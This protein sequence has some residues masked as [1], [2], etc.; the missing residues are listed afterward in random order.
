MPAGEVYDFVVVGAGSAG[1]AVAHRLATRTDATVLLIEAG[2]PDT[3]P[4]IHDERM[5]A[6][7]SLWG[8]SEIDWGYVTEPQDG[9]HG[10]T[11][12]VAR[13]KV[14][15]GS[16]SINAMLYVRGNRRDFD[17]WQELGNTG[18]GY[19]DVLPHFREMENF[20]G[21]ASVY[22]GADGPLSV[23]YH[24]DPTPVADR[25]F[26]AGAEIG[27]RA[28]D[29]RFDYNAEHQEDT[30][31]YY[32]AT[33][34]RE[35]RRASTAVAYLRPI[36]D[37]PNFTLRSNAQ[38]SRVVIEHGRAV[39][40]EYIVDGRVERVRADREVVLSC[41]AY[42]SPKL[43]MLSG[44]GPAATL[45]GHGIDVVADLP[46]V[47][48]NLQDHMILGVVY[49]SKQEQPSEPTLIAET[50]LF[51]RSSQ[52]GP[53]APPNVQFKVGGLKF[54]SPE[55]DRPGP[56]FT[57]APVIVQPRSV[58][59]IGLRSNDPAATAVLQPNYL[60]DPHDV[61]TFVESIELARTLAHTSAYAEFTDVE[62]AP[63]PEVRSRAELAEF[64]RRNAGTLW[65]PVGTCSMGEVVDSELRVR[66][67]DGLRVA[68]A[69]VMPKIVA[70]NTNAA[71][72][73]IGEKAAALISAANLTVHS[74]ASEG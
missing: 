35:H 44:I 64:A 19:Q 28:E 67:V 54:V 26:E 34:T 59:T 21:G 36:M 65:H 14:W 60:A 42:E 45:A 57:F 8:P 53:D 62:I 52:V 49:L 58:G 40:I 55:L 9:L 24:S 12:P 29:R 16:S 63:G 68:D 23:I 30:V 1:C 13:G 4:E 72:I 69:S 73:M 25:L 38:V 32:Q 66:G 51:T 20:E 70:G 37:R 48:Q 31:F 47:G 71:C 10:R 50:G 6:T 46:G 3:R 33:K 17:H 2:G 39:G 15:G 7:M 61:D 18:W 27:L 11:V 74:G 56:G 43:L 5:A 22:R 41:G